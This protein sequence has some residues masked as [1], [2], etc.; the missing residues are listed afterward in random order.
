MDAF[1]LSRLTADLL[2]DMRLHAGDFDC[3][4]VKRC[5]EI[6][7]LVIGADRQAVIEI[8]IRDAVGPANQF[9]HGPVHEYPHERDRRKTAKRDR[10]DQE[11]AKG[12]LVLRHL[13]VYLGQ[14]EIGVDHAEGLL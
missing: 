8:A 5:R 1:Q 13:S 6:S 3:H 12:R 11:P 4:F 7:Q 2:L 10:S 9:F 14:R